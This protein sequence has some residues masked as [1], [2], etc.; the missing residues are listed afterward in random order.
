MSDRDQALAW[1]YGPPRDRHDV[2]SFAGIAGQAFDLSP[3]DAR[4]WLDRAGIEHVRVLYEGQTVLGGLLRV[5]MGQ[6]FGG[7]AVRMTGIAGVAVPPEQRG[8]GVARRLMAAALAELRAAETALSTL[9]PATTTL[10]RRGGYEIAGARYAVELPAASLRGLRAPADVSLRPLGPEDEDAQLAL[11]AAEA[12]RGAG[13]LERGPYI[14][15]RIRSPRVGAARG[16]LVQ[17]DGRAEGYAYLSQRGVERQGRHDYDVVV[18]DLAAGTRRAAL[19][20]LALLA[21]H[22]GLERRVV[23]HIA[24]A[25]PLLLLLPERHEHVRRLD[26]WM[27]RIV[28]VPAALAAR[29]YPAGARGTLVLELDDDVLP[30]NAGRHRLDVADG[31]GRVFAA[32]AGPGSDD[33][34]TLRLH[35]RGLPPLY[36]GHMT[37]D[38]LAVAGLLQGPP[39]ACALAA[40]LF[41]GPAP[42]MSDM[43]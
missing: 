26:P 1:D 24:P 20:L 38:A 33:A 17:A 36:S 27:L 40:A 14:W 5:P 28:H 8:R 22:A 32:G 10:Y 30:E 18:T 42:T 16:Y 6:W 31:R 4:A 34:P 25:H 35:V 23:L 7:R 43:F 19:R 12:A 3:V 13:Q 37:P 21:E 9:Y 41:A 39:E 15:G 2:S 11:A 29:G